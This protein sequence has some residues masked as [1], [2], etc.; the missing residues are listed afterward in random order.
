MFNQSSDK[1]GN[2]TQ[3]ELFSIFAVTHADFPGH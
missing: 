1:T 2:D 3:S